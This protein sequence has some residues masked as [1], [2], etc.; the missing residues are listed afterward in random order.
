MSGKTTLPLQHSQIVQE[1][2]KRPGLIPIDIDQDNHKLVWFD[3]GDH[4]LTESYFFTSTEL[5][6]STQEK[7]ILFTTEISTL[8]SND[9]LTNYIYPSGFIFHM[10]RCG[11]TLLSK[12]LARSPNHLVIS[13]APPHYLIWEHLKG[14]W[15]KP[16]E[17]SKENLTTYR[18]LI[19]TMG[20]KRVSDQRAH[21]I[22]FTT[23][24]I[25]FIDFIHKVFPDVPSL[26]LYRDPAEVMVSFLRQGAGWFRFK[27][28]ELGAFTTGC[29]VEETK[30]M[31]PLTFFEKFLIRFVS[32]ALKA[33]VEG[34]GYLNYDQ[35]NPQNFE[36]VLN[37][38][39]YTTSPDQIALMQRQFN[40]YSRDDSDT[41]PFVSDKTDK[42][43]EITL[44]IKSCVEGELTELYDQ[45]ERSER[46]LARLLT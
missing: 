39:N 18:N 9:I 23:H 24:N 30:A 37:A 16:L 10:G 7:P 3:I 32:A 31:K 41:T 42:Q 20:R 13:E 6:I 15:L 11:S 38:F 36:V 8:A 19:L 28:T 34:L 17:F 33:S 40:F 27:D 12:A 4:Q 46:N 2:N 35:L 29:S 5:L 22:K 14:N 44:E 1:I 25:L 45:L 43:K 26:F 21:F